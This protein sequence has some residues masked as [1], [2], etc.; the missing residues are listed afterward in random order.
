MYGWEGKEIKEEQESG[1]EKET[2]FSRVKPQR[3][4]KQHRGCGLRQMNPATVQRRSSS[5]AGK[6]NPTGQRPESSSSVGEL[7]LHRYRHSEGMVKYRDSGH[8]WTFISASAWK[9][10][11]NATI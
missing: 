7:Q 3:H 11:I 2:F 5:D 4:G 8:G 10:S 9:N 6:T 1:K